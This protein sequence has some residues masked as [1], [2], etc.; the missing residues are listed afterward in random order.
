MTARLLAAGGGGLCSGTLDRRRKFN[1]HSVK[2]MREAFPELEVID[3]EAMT[4]RSACAGRAGTA[5]C[6]APGWEE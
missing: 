3:F 5:A 6:R 1:A 4:V 2:V